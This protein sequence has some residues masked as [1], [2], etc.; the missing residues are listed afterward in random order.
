MSPKEKALFPYSGTSQDSY[1]CLW[2]YCLSK[3]LEISRVTSSSAPLHGWIELTYQLSPISH[4]S[5]M[6]RGLTWHWA[7]NYLVTRASKLLRLIKV[8]RINI[9]ALGSS[10]KSI[11]MVQ[12]TLSW[13]HLI[14]N[15]RS[16]HL[17]SDLKNTQCYHRYSKN[18]SEIGISL[19]FTKKRHYRYNQK[20]TDLENIY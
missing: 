15:S 3:G 1:K 12:A 20:T 17:N 8:Q 19:D 10:D 7:G 11:L 2:K 16:N 5:S 18:L 9:I 13:L 14:L 4:K 6:W